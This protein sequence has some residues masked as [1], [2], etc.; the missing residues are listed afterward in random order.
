MEKRNHERYAQRMEDPNRPKALIGHNCP[1]TII[2]HE[3]NGDKIR[4]TGE[5]PVYLYDH[6]VI[7]QHNDEQARKA[8]DDV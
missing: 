5:S 6:E 3:A 2:F 7:D 4:K 1:F 8:G